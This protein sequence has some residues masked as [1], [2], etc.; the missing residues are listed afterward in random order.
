MCAYVGG[1]I[2]LGT[3]SFF[4][5]APPSPQFP[6]SSS[7]ITTQVPSANSSPR[8]R[9]KIFVISSIIEKPLE[10]L[11]DMLSSVIEGGIVMA[12][13]VNDRSV[14]PNQIL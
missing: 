1:A 6:S 10:E 9:P 4:R 7:L 8:L 3:K 13:V 11:A 14:T 12:K 5:T 2:T